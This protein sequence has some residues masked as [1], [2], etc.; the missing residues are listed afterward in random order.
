MSDEE[1][2][3]KG[4]GIAIQVTR[5]K[6]LTRK[7]GLSRGLPEESRAFNLVRLKARTSAR[8]QRWD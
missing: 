4:P 7:A 3:G 2:P 8:S 6:A 1:D 5:P